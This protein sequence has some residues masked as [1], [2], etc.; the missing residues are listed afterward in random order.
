[1][2]EVVEGDAGDLAGL[3]P[4][5]SGATPLPLSIWLQR[6]SWVGRPACST[7]AGRPARCARHGDLHLANI[8]LLHGRPVLFDC[9]EF[10]RLASIDVL[11][12]LAFL[13]HGPA[14][15]RR[16]PRLG[17]YRPTTTA[18]LRTRGSR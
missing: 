3:A 16:V 7:V 17:G 12:D 18:A 14:R 15:A 10:E 5:S 4:V 8:V 6:R 13:R 2:R 1:M 11:Y 9:L